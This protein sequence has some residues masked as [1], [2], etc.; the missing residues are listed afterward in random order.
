VLPDKTFQQVQA[1][2]HVIQD[3]GRGETVGKQSG[4]HDRHDGILPRLDLTRAVASR[5]SC[6][7]GHVFQKNNHFQYIRNYF[8][9]G[10]AKM[11]G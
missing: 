10:V 6:P 5:E 7:G 11:I 3:F 8:L 2:R 4:L 9:A 1:I